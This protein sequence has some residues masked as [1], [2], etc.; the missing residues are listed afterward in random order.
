MWKFD[1]PP[2]S[3]NKKF[4]FWYCKGLSSTSHSDISKQKNIYTRFTRGDHDLASFYKGGK[5]QISFVL[6]WIFRI[7]E[8]LLNAPQSNIK[9]S[10]T[11][12][13][14]YAD[15]TRGDDIQSTVEQNSVY[16]FW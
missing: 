6:K 11:V 9:Q 3:L 1:E 15:L 16:K 10:N 13:R 8:G 4:D 12:P 14:I 2:A 7:I 5:V